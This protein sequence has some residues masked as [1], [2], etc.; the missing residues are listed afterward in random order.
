MHP[1]AEFPNEK[2]LLHLY[3]RGIDAAVDRMWVVKV[4]EIQRSEEWKT[5]R[6]WM[7]RVIK[8]A[9]TLDPI[10]MCGDTKVMPE[11]DLKRAKSI[12]R[13]LKDLR[14]RFLDIQRFDKRLDEVASVHNWN[15]SLRAA[16][17]RMNQTLHKESPNLS[18]THRVELIRLTI[19]R[20]ELN[21]AESETAVSRLLSPSRQA[22]KAGASRGP[23]QG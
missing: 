20:T 18:K 5:H 13:S 19:E 8:L 2:P 12:S 7:R 15:S 22:N 1:D 9:Q 23:R 21:P 14:E 16:R 10:L 6:D 3:E 4:K 17:T 11:R